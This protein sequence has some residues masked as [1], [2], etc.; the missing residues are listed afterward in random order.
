ML[1]EEQ[2]AKAHGPTCKRMS[3]P[4]VAPF[5]VVSSDG[6]TP[7]GARARQCRLSPCSLSGAA[8]A[9]AGD[10]SAILLLGIR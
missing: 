6:G 1:N 7:A 4:S 8:L 9:T 5:P 10:V 3:S 2:E